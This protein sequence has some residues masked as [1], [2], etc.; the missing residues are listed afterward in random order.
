MSVTNYFAF[1]G[2]I[3]QRDVLPGDNKIQF[4]TSHIARSD[5]IFILID[6][7]T[8]MSYTTSKL[9]DYVSVAVSFTQHANKRIFV[10]YYNM[11]DTDIQAFTE[12]DYSLQGLSLFKPVTIN[13]NIKDTW[14][15]KIVESMQSTP[16]GM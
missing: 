12:T 1:S 11:P 2:L 8:A 13:K 4:V 16:A 15:T 9:R 3:V 6:D 10:L 5:F 14:M 7:H